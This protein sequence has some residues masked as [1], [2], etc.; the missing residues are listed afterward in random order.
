[1]ETLR[2][3]IAVL[4]NECENYLRTIRRIEKRARDWSVYSGLDQLIK[5][6]SSTIP[7]MD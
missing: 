5:S 6:V 3:T 4:S 7:I 2:L 1:V